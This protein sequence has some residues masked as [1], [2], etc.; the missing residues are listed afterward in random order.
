VPDET[1][2]ALEDLHSQLSAVQL[3]DAA[4][5]KQLGEVTDAIRASLDDPHSPHR[6][7]LGER[8]EKVAVEF[9][10]EHPQIARRLRAVIDSL[11]E[12]GF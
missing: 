12:A 8:L 6:V 10:V 3:D 2:K 5:Q 9:E 4:K 1:K 7:T 11:S